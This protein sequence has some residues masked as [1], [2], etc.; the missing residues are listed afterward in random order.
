MPAVIPELSADRDRAEY[1][2][3]ELG[4]FQFQRGGSLF[5]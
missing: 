5:L 2:A 1:D 3:K 4:P